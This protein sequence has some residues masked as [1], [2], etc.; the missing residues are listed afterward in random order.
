MLIKNYKKINKF[1]NVYYSYLRLNMLT[2]ILSNK[3]KIQ[4]KDIKKYCIYTFRNR[5]VFSSMKMSRH[6]YKKF[7]DNRTYSNIYIK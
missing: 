5:S 7:L 1:L 2:H 4:L 3:N 6:T